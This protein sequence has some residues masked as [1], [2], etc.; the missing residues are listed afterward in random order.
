[1]AAKLDYY[2]PNITYKYSLILC[3]LCHAKAHKLDFK[4]AREVNMRPFI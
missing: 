1:M 2:K 4:T 3:Y